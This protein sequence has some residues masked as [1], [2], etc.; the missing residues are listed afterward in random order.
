MLLILC[1]CMCV[2]RCTEESRLKF[3]EMLGFRW[4]LDPCQICQLAIS[5]EW[6]ILVP[7]FPAVFLA[8]SFSCCHIPGQLSVKVVWGWQGS[9]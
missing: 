5:A 1:L 7:S 3:S 4:A 2:G 8:S 6:L 9:P